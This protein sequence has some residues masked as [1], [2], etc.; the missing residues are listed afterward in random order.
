MRAMMRARRSA[1]DGSPLMPRFP[2]FQTLN[3]YVRRMLR[4]S[5]EYC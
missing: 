4:F 2:A 3:I 1:D 5:D